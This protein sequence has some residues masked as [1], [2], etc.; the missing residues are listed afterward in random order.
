[1]EGQQP[2]AVRR[3]GKPTGVGEPQVQT[4]V[5]ESSSAGPRSTSVVVG[6]PSCGRVLGVMSG[7]G[8]RVVVGDRGIGVKVA[9][10]PET[11]E[12]TTVLEGDTVPWLADPPLRAGVG[13]VSRVG[14]RTGVRIILGG[15]GV[16][17]ETTVMTRTGC[18]YA[19]GGLP[20]ATETATIMVSTT[21]VPNPNP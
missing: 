15:V 17:T 11:P 1:M 19:V 3:N 10:E 16:T 13:G 7:V 6:P 18:G 20:P 12:V 2:G 9:S 4:G 8:S 21:P 14:I 5:D